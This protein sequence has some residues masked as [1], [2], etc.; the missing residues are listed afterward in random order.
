MAS[1][2]LHFVNFLYKN[3][4][5]FGLYRCGTLNGKRIPDDYVYI[6]VMDHG[7]GD[8]ESRKCTFARSKK[9]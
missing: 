3:M 1:W 2:E 7:L 6:L 9:K 5:D 4:D 8:R